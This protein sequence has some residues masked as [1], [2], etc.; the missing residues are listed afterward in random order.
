[1]AESYDNLDGKVALVTGGAHRIG[2]AVVRALHRAG[3]DVAIHYRRSRQGADA[4]RAEL[5]AARPDSVHLLQ[6]DL[7]D[8]AALPRLI[9][10]VLDWRPRLDLLVNNASSFYPTPLESADQQQWEELF[11]S[12]LKAPFFLAQAAAAALSRSGGA[13]VNLVDI[14][15]ERPL[16][17]YPIYSMAKAGNAMMVKSL[18]RELGPRVRVNGVAPGAI[19]WPEQGLDAEQKAS[20]LERT[21][22][23]RPGS[24]EDIAR[25]VLFLAAGP[26]YI[27]G[28]II[29][30][31][32]GRSVQH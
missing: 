16:G 29:A 5:E 25:T 4:L 6:A 1:M 31:D 32:G 20:I 18:A 28:Q 13:I 19:L 27:T 17:G 7:H 14:H 30:V 26:D 2:A 21:A 9:E 22:L 8:T 3:M 23:K 12:N 10:G 15:A 24:P 11:G